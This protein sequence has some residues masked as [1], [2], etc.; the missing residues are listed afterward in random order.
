MIGKSP[1]GL[2][3]L[4]FLGTR[5]RA[6]DHGPSV[7]LAVPSC[8]MSLN[9]ALAAAK[10][11]GEDGAGSRLLAGRVLWRTSRYIPVRLISSGNSSRRL[12]GGGPPAMTFMLGMD[13]GAMRPGV[14][15]DVTP[16]SGRLCLQSTR[17]P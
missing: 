7:C 1:Y 11:S 2:Q 6:D 14:D 5:W 4:S 16:S 13:G 9:A 8:S 10:R 12:S 15:S 17:S 3:P